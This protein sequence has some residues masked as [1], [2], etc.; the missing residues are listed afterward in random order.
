VNSLNGKEA[1]ELDFDICAK[2][3]ITKY[4]I[5]SG[6]IKNVSCG[7]IMEKLIKSRLFFI[8]FNCY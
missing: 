6:E 1:T 7:T 2:G 5:I 3:S 4:T 8:F